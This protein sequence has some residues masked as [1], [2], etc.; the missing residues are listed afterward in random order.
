MLFLFYGEAMMTVNVD[1]WAWE[2]LG[3]TNILIYFFFLVDFFLAFFLVDFLAFFLVDFFLAFFL[4]T[5]FLAF[6]LVAFFFWKVG[7]KE[8]N[9]W[10]RFNA[11]NRK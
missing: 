3:G 8:N 11:I 10:E 4:V 2:D 9:S 6:F 7:E 5:F 1:P